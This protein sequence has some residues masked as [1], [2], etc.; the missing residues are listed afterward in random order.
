MESGKGRRGDVEVV[1]SQRSC[2][3][4]GWDGEREFKERAG[5]EKL[6]GAM[7]KS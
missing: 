6:P 4:Y 3:F 1:Y 5:L 7:R 2:F